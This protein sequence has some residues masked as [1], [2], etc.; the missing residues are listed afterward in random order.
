M[1]RAEPATAELVRTAMREVAAVARARDIALGEADVER[2]MAVYRGFSADTTSS[3]QR[4]LAAGRPSE[5]EYQNGAVVRFGRAAGV[6]TPVH[7]TIYA[8]Q[9]PGEVLARQV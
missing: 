7:E 6:P 8:S 3:M 5:L 9:L 4:D 2:M 1:T